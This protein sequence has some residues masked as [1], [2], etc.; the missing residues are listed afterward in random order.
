VTAVNVSEDA[1]AESDAA[2]VSSSSSGADLTSTGAAAAT[3]ELNDNGDEI[4]ASQE[5]K[6]PKRKVRIRKPTYAVRKVR[7]MIVVFVCLV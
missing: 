4:T 2:S 5:T 1:A 6:K 3:S 7:L